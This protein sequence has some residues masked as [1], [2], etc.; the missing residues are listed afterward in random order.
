MNSVH[1]YR[2]VY[3][4]VDVQRWLHEVKD[5]LYMVSQGKVIGGARGKA[6]YLLENVTGDL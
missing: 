6:R 1:L 2:K 4:S 5:E 3:K